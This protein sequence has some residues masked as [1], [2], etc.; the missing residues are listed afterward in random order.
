MHGPKAAGAASE[1]FRALSA[2]WSAHRAMPIFALL[3][4]IGLIGL[5]RLFHSRAD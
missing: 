1:A 3:E 2:G 5:N 4:P